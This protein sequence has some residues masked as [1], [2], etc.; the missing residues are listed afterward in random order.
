MATVE[1]SIH[2]GASLAE[3]WD[4]YFKIAGW[5][6]W[7]DGF[8]SVVSSEGYPEQGGTLTWRTIPAGRGEVA[9]RVID[10][11]ARRHHVVEFSDQ[12][13]RG[14]FESRFAIDGDGT[15]ISQRQTYR[16]VSA[17][18]IVRLGSALFV[19]SQLRLALERSLLDF[20]QYAEQKAHG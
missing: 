6:D 19:R 12:T 3:T 20:K 17:G 5:P 18:P 13:M 8:A 11:E 10:H 7:V 1:G 9:E 16:V 14:E 2:V 15:R 4:A